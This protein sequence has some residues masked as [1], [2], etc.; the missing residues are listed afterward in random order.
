MKMR[1]LFLFYL[2]IFSGNFF[3]TSFVSG[4]KPEKIELVNADVSEFDQALN[5]RAT[6][7]IGHVIFR[8][9]HAIMHCDSAYLY[10]EEN[11]LEAFNNIKIIQGDTLTLTGSRLFYDGNTRIAQ[12]FDNVVMTDRKMV[13]HTSRLDYDMDHDIAS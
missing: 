2:C 12:V 4:Q 8:H 9:E 5:A 1:K 7:L 13:L 6:R 11:R 3:L 10:R